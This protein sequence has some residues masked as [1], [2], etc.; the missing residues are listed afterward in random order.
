MGAYVSGIICLRP[1]LG[2]HRAI[3]DDDSEE[4]SQK[5]SST[6]DLTLAHISRRQSIFPAPVDGSSWIGGT[7]DWKAEGKV[8]EMVAKWKEETILNERKRRRTKEDESTLGQRCHGH[9]QGRKR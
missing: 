1:I 9:R 5:S 8:A 2:R 4:N 3:E 7:R 6:N